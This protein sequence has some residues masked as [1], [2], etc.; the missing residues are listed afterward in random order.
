MKVKRSFPLT[1]VETV[2]YDESGDPKR[3][4]L[5]FSNS[6][7]ILQAQ[8]AEDASD[9]VEKIVQGESHVL[10]HYLQIAMSLQWRIFHICSMCQV[11]YCNG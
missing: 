4:C 11:A 2:D 6:V 10:P 5:T 9:W 7:E 8:T 1:S 3:F